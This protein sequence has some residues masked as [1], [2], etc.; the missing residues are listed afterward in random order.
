MKFVSLITTFLMACTT[1]LAQ[2]KPITSS[3]GQRYPM[4]EFDANRSKDTAYTQSMVMLAHQLIVKEYNK[5][6]TLLKDSTVLRLYNY[7]AALYRNT[8]THNDSSL[9]YGLKVS[10]YAKTHNNVEFEVKGLFQQSLY[11]QLFKQNNAEALRLN[12]KAYGI[13]EKADHDPQVFWRI[14]YNLGD[15]YLKINEFD[16]S[17][18]YFK[19][20]E[21][22]IKSGTGLSTVS[23][24]SYQVA[25]WQS[26]ASI[27]NN[28][29]DFLNAELHFKKA[30]DYLN[31]VPTKGIKA[32]IHADYSL[33][34][35]EQKRAK[36]AVENG[37]RAENLW[38][39]TKAT[40]ELMLL[41]S[42]LA[43]YYMELKEFEKAEKVA[44]E[45]LKNKQVPKRAQ[46]NAYQIMHRLSINKGNWLA[47]L[48]FFKKYIHLRDSLDS[49]HN[50]EELYKMQSR[51]EMDIMEAN[52]KE[53]KDRQMQAFLHIQ[54]ENEIQ[55][56]RTQVE[57]QNYQAQLKSE[58][59]KREYET[60]TLREISLK[61]NTQAIIQASNQESQINKL[62]IKELEQRKQIEEQ[63]KRSLAAGLLLTLLSGLVLL[64]YNRK[65]KKRNN[66][67]VEK[68][69]II[70]TVTQKMAEIEISA[71]RSQM[72]PHFIFNCLNSIKLYTL[73]NDSHAASEYLTKFS[74]LIRLVLENSRMEK[75]PLEQELETLKLYIEMEEMRFKG[76]VNYTI[77]VDAK[78]DTQFIEIPPLLIQPFVENAIWNG[79]M[80]KEFGGNITIDLQNIDEKTLQIRITD[81]GIGRKKSL[82]LQ[83]KTATKNKSYGMQVTNERIALINHIYKTETKIE[84]IDLE[85]RNKNPI[86]TQVIIEIPLVYD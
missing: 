6:N 32:Q 12:L 18:K 38:T 79:L 80:H 15:T 53:E 69:K 78:V 61:Q 76:K 33:F 7:L 43:L 28:K 48:R 71:L 70:E 35:F 46:Q 72:N 11:Y 42:N 1:L 65:L 50:K 64:W 24:Y 77:Q 29:K 55:A 20:S 58:K 86:G 40:R 51:F 52:A 63:T 75:I 17:L 39:E 74:R 85:D 44:S 27:Y 3:A 23:T 4:P 47:G 31:K 13:V 34:L 21:E 10:E 67:L 56:L 59:Q 37:L 81:D 49:R 25:I 5:T 36:E 68:N 2:N 41:R 16:K 22:L 60:Q 14:C 82:E 45:I 26:I 54:N 30:I 57:M 84:I 19:Q 62:K 73:Q 9:Y 8:P 66:D 83:S